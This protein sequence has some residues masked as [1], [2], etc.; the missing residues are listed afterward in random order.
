RVCVAGASSIVLVAIRPPLRS[1]LSLHRKVARDG[2]LVRRSLRVVLASVLPVIEADGGNS[3]GRP[4]AGRSSTISDPR[5]PRR[6][7]GRGLDGAA[8]RAARVHAA[9][10]G[11]SGGGHGG[12]GGHGRPQA[13]SVGPGAPLPRAAVSLVSHGV[14]GVR[15]E[16][17]RVGKEWRWGW[18]AEDL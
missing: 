15:S 14:H 17:R 12:H 16:E 7:N 5:R 6:H 1:H 8:Q 11:G 18:V 3:E 10:R 4:Y 9:R 2:A 13:H